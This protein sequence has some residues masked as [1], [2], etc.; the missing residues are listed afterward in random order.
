MQL[1]TFINKKRNPWFFAVF[2]VLTLAL[3]GNTLGHQY[4]LDDALVLTKNSFTTQGFSGIPDILKHDSFTGFFGKEKKLVQG[5]RYR[6][7]SLVSFALEYAFF[8]ENPFVSHLINILLYATLVFVLFWV[9]QSIF[10]AFV[11]EMPAKTLA[12]LAALLFLIHPLHT[13]VVANIKG[14]DEILSL[15]FAALSFGWLLYEPFK[16][17]IANVVLAAAFLFLGCLAKEQA[18]AF[19]AIVPFFFYLTR[20]KWL[21]ALTGL[22][23]AGLSYVLIRQVVLGQA[24]QVE[25]QEL[26]NNPF[27]QATNGQHYATILYTWLLY[28]KLLVF[29][30]PLTFDYYPK[31]IPILGFQSPMVW[32]A[33]LLIVLLLWQ[34]VR[35]F[36]KQALVSFL[37]I[38]FIAS[39][40]LLSNLFFSVGTFMNE[41][42]L[43]APSFFWTV[44][45]AYVLWQLLQSPRKRVFA[46]ALLGLMFLAYPIKTF[47]RNK[48][49]YNDFTL[50]TT[51][52]KTSRNSAKSNCS[53]G[54]A[55]WEKGKLASNEK[56]QSNLYEQAESYLKKAVE[57]YPDYVD[58]LLLLGNVSY[59]LHHDSALAAKYYWAVLQRQ[60]LHDQAYKN[61]L[62][63]LG[64]SKNSG[65]QQDYYHKL[66]K[67]K[68]QDYT[69][70]YRLGV[71]YARYLGDLSQGISYLEKAAALD[72]TKVEVLKD[73]G[74]AYGML[75]EAQRSYQV[76][77]AALKLAPD[78]KQLCNNIAMALQQL[79]RYA[80]AQEYRD[81][82]LSR[83]CP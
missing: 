18:I 46:L 57:I 32:L 16:S 58:A 10:H 48:A 4:A 53:A 62:I 66:E 6:P 60:S 21:P 44:L 3:Y 39:F 73:L 70:N 26:M 51:D 69:L 47:T 41:R 50:F 27:L 81:K 49:W 20:K 23:L 7:L 9:A 54:G 65:L 45:L 22:V 63:V 80:E 40:I 5:G 12:F 28:A 33:L 79:G 14:R 82:A 24:L 2:L 72:S 67:I 17:K 76:S 8:G 29:P 52:V 64:V 43:F 30:H 34:L 1:Q 11:P 68:P 15:L 38:S 35:Q 59:D 25:S 37:L 36:R 55:L 31:Q 78:D 83:V 13:E 75:G 42:F 61:M 74:T 19:V 71:L 77:L 56:V